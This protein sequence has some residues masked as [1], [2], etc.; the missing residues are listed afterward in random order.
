MTTTDDLQSWQDHS[1]HVDMT[2]KNVTGNF[3]NI[4]QETKVG[5]II[6]DPRDLQVTIDIS[7]IRVPISEVSVV[8]PLI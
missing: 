5:G 7:A 1:T 2:D 6:L 3:A 4:L 8:V